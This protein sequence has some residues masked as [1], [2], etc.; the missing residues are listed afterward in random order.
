MDDASP[1]GARRC[2]SIY[3]AREVIDPENED[4]RQWAML[5]SPR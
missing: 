1:R 5:D 4:Y 2:H 3:D